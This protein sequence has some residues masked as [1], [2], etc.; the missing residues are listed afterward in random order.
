[1]KARDLTVS[2]LMTTQLITVN[3]S[4]PIKEARAEMD[5]GV[6]RHL[7]VVDD[8]GRLVGVV[9]DRDLLTSKRG[10]RV[11]DVMTRDV[12]TTRPDVPAAEAASV[13]LDHKISSVLVVNDDQLLVGM[14]TQTDYLELARRAL[15]GLPL[16]R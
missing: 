4:E 14:I 10:H 1:M 6:V 9:S 7:P 12:I 15:L 5:I 2:D 3:A 13:M 16:E 8:R 11:A